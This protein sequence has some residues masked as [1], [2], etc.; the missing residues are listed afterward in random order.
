MRYLVVATIIISFFSCDNTVDILEEPRDI[1]IVYGILSASDTAHYIRVERVF[2]RENESAFDLA[3]DP[4]ELYYEN[5]EVSLI[6][7]SERFALQKIDATD[8]GF[9]RQDGVFAQSPNTVYKISNTDINLKEGEDY[10]LE[11]NRNIEGLPLI[12]SST[13]IVGASTIRSPLTTL[14]FDNN[15]FTT[16]SW[17]EGEFATIY[18]LFLDFKYRERA[19]GSGDLFEP[20]V[21]RWNIASDIETTR[22]DIQGVQF[23]SFL[24]GAIPV[25][26][27]VERVL[28][29]V[30]LILVSGSAEIQEFIRIGDAN[31]GIT[32]SQDV[33]TFSNLSEGRG[34]F[35]SLYSEVKDNVQ[36][37]NKTLDSIRMGSITEELNFN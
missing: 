4:E 21:V 16:F 22:I 20:K 33:P 18:D 7:G 29:S 26:D 35:G 1:P 15:I 28:E 34:I 25:D 9:P 10:M 14:N 12:T 32:S 17:R 19:S 23:Y 2:V 3:Q 11:I 5:P 8:D 30:D 31:L 37:T 36:L 13:N 27:S 6:N 24:A